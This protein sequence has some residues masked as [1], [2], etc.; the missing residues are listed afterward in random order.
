MISEQNKGVE[1]L[2]EFMR[3]SFIKTPPI[4]G[5]RL[6]MITE[7]MKTQNVY[8]QL[9]QRQVVPETVMP[10]TGGGID[11]SLIKTIIDE[12]VSRQLKSLNESTGPTMRGMRFI[13]GNAFQFVDNKGN[14]YEAV[15]KLKKRAKQ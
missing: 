6:D 5:D 14:L 9:P 13:N 8:Q 3:E 7:D 12:S 4:T 11:Y 10:H 2:P 1:A 15:L